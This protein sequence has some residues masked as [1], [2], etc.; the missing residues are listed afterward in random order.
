MNYKTIDKLVEAKFSGAVESEAGKQITGL[1]Y[2]KKFV[3]LPFHIP[4]WT[5]EDMKK[6]C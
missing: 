4:I 2:L 3:Q 1:D 5:E 6:I